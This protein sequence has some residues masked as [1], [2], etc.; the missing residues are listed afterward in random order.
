MKERSKEWKSKATGVLNKR[1]LVFK[2]LPV[3]VDWEKRKEATAD[4]VER[5]V[6]KFRE[7]SLQRMSKIQE[8]WND[9]KVVSL[10]DKL[11]FLFGVMVRLLHRALTLLI[12]L[13]ERRG[14]NAVNRFQTAVDVSSLLYLVYPA[15]S[16]AD[17]WHTLSKH[18]GFYLSE[19]TLT[20]T[21]TLCV[22]FFLSSI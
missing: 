16:V 9:S 2:D 1:T 11:S 8:K 14:L 13:A 17:R 4:R 20:R 12:V 19:C 15:E 6:Q 7:K 22:S 18:S 3:Q 10:R 5:E 21:R